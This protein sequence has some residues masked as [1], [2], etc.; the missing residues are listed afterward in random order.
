MPEQQDQELFDEIVRHIGEFVESDV[1]YLT[2]DSHLATS[3]E[4]MS[5]LKLVELLLYLEDCFNLEFDDSVVG[6]LE[7]M[8]DLVHYVRDLRNAQQQPA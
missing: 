6:R 1:S 4:G 2:P 5:S 7:S 8:R 3:I